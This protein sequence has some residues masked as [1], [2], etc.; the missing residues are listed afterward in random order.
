MRLWIFSK[1]RADIKDL[2]LY[3]RLSLWSV[4]ESFWCSRLMNTHRG[5]LQKTTLKRTSS[6]KMEENGMNLVF[7]CVPLFNFCISW[8]IFTKICN[9]FIPVKAIRYFHIFNFHKFIITDTQLMLQYL[10]PSWASRYTWQWYMRVDST[11]ATKNINSPDEI[12]EVN[13]KNYTNGQNR[14]WWNTKTI[15]NGESCRRHQKVPNK[16]TGS[17]GRNVPWTSVMADSL[18]C[19]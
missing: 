18:M 9:N 3:L 12:N 6:R 15:T 16:M 13:I 19:L 14:K 7:V 17:R 5:T 8:Q 10:V 2:K 11:E 4:T 1:F